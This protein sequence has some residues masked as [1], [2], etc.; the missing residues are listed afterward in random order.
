MDETWTRAYLVLARQP[1]TREIKQK[2]NHTRNPD[3]GFRISVSME[4]GDGSDGARIQTT[5]IAEYCGHGAS[6]TAFILNVPM[7]CTSKRHARDAQR[8]NC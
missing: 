4:Y 1:A 6:K 7:T 2:K 8:S 5:Y 3:V